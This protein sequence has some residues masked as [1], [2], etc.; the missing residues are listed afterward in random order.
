VATDII[1][2][3][4]PIGPAADSDDFE[5]AFTAI[6][7]I[8]P[9]TARYTLLRAMKDPD[10]FPATDLGLVKALGAGDTSARSRIEQRARAWRP[11]R[12]YAAMLLWKHAAAGG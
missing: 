4:L 5:K 12:A 8:G 3:R 2:Q 7:G 1:E 9:W 10:A 6:K 11:W